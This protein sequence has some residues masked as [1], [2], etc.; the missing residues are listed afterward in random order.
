L[1]GI[2]AEGE[3]GPDGALETVILGIGLNLSAPKEGYAPE[4]CGQAISLAE[5]VGPIVSF[6]RLELCAGIVR[7]FEEIYRAL[8]R[9]DFLE[10]YRAAS[11]ILGKE[12][13]YQKDGERQEGLAV[14]IDDEASLLVESGGTTK[15]LS[16]GEI[17]FVR[18]L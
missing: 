10:E 2:L 6:D 4:I 16:T 18:P 8:P 13:S 11:C 14:G 3:F 9:V 15:V 17:S 7:A 5:M 1:C 12:I